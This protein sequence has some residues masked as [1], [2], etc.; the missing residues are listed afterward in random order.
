[1]LVDDP[2][3]PGLTAPV[4]AQLN[5]RLVDAMHASGYSELQALSKVLDDILLNKCVY[6]WVADTFHNSQTQHSRPPNFGAIYSGLTRGPMSSTVDRPFCFYC[7]VPLREPCSH[8][9]PIPGKLIDRDSCP[10]RLM[11]AFSDDFQPILPTL[12]TLIFAHG[13]TKAQLESDL[14][15]PPLTVKTLATW[16]K[17]TSDDPRAVPNPVK[18]VLAYVRRHKRTPTGQ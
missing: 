8:P 10:H 12:I 13:P 2:S 14:L 17:E 16:L 4:T 18:F 6:C 3:S 9:P 5:G 15:L 11:D 1:M 7:W